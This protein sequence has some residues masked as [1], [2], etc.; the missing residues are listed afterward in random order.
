MCYPDWSVQIANLITA[1]FTINAF[2]PTSSFHLKCYFASD[3]LFNLLPWFNDSL[4]Y[5][6][7]NH[8]SADTL[9]LGGLAALLGEQIQN[10]ASLSF[11][12][13]IGCNKK[14][15]KGVSMIPSPMRSVTLNCMIVLYSLYSG[16]VEILWCSLQVNF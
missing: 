13:G 16:S 3:L 12:V 4:L 14:E 10:K 2:K 15:Q 6:V 11:F 8:S 7:H 1:A 9:L 5:V